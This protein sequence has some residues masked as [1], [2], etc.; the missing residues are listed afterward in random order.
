[1]R[2]DKCNLENSVYFRNE[3][4]SHD[5]MV[6]W[7]LLVI[8]LLQALIV[9][10]WLVTYLH[11]IFTAANLEKR[12][13]RTKSCVRAASS[14]SLVLHTNVLLGRL[15]YVLVCIGAFLLSILGHRY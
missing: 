1:M 2:S 12:Q 11:A 10:V 4:Q 15:G 6:T 14:S 9:T 7:P 3:R 8:D 5:M 13:R